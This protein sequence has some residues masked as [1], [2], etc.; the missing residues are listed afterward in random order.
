MRFVGRSALGA[1]AAVGA[2]AAIAAPASAH[3][4]T[5]PQGPAVVGAAGGE[6]EW[7]FRPFRVK[8][9]KVKGASAASITWPSQTLALSLKYA[10]CKT[11]VGKVSKTEGP[12]IATKFEA[13][14]TITYHAN[15]YVELAEATI[16]IGTPFKC[17]VTVEAQTLPAKAVKKPT[18]EFTAASFL[19][20][21]IPT[22][23]KKMPMQNVVAI[24]NAEVKGIHYT[25]S[26]GF[27]EEL[28]N[29]EGKAGYYKGGLR[30]SIKSANLLFK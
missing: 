11:H 14:V 29:T 2:A 13:P 8:C 3:E 25:L 26:E 21:E 20:E 23:S 12:G 22:K 9:E 30:A 18:E 10:K 28:E 27:C 6:Q 19:T 5:S 4:F 15:G 17:K 7:D 24:N 16:S 1:L